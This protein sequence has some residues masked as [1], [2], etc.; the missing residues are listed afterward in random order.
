MLELTRESNVEVLRQTALILEQEN[1]KLITKVLQLTQEN[2][3]L[4][5]EPQMD[6]ALRL[7]QLSQQ[8]ATR[9]KKLFG[10]SSEKRD[11]GSEPL[12]A[13]CCHCE[14]PPLPLALKRAQVSLTQQEL[15]APS[16]PNTISRLLAESY[17][18]GV[19]LRDGPLPASVKWDHG[20]GWPATGS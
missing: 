1:K 4:R 12:G 20:V 19:E 17:T 13:S 10:D 18:T 9:N 8:L 15:F 6:L 2:L 16:P 3:A 11:G 14:V 7:E 5:G